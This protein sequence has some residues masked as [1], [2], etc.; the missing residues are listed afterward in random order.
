[1][2]PLLE[3]PPCPLAPFFEH[4]LFHGEERGTHALIPKRYTSFSAT[5]AV[6]FRS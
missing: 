1:L 4:F 3:A 6:C 2:K 5:D